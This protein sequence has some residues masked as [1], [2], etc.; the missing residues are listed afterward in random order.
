MSFISSFVTSFASTLNLCAKV[1]CLLSS[2]S[3]AS[4]VA[5]VKDPFCLR[6]VDN[7]VSFSNFLYKFNE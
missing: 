6:P 5:T 2:S 3:L 7:P 4:V 1:S